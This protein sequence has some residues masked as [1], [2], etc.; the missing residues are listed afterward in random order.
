VGITSVYVTH[1]QAEALVMSDRV[2]VMNKGV[3][4]QIGDPQTIY[5]HPANTFVANFIGVANLVPGI[6]RG[7]SGGFCELEVP[8]GNGHP[9][10]RLLAAGAENAQLQQSLTLSLR[11][12]DI[13]VHLERPDGEAGSNVF[14]GEV[15]QTV[16]LGN[17]LDCR[18]KVG[19]HE[20]SVQIEHFDQIAPQ[21]KVYLSFAPD[22][23]LCLAE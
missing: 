17:V 22:H 20:L 11:P 13:A 2:V 7:R 6:L 23:G 18:V 16:Y 3:I 21:Q 12:E 15:I 9:P 8:I 19:S 14:E 4:Q 1:D 5:A 10:L